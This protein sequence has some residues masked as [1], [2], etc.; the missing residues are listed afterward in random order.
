MVT[1]T[2]RAVSRVITGKGALSIEWV[3]LLL[4]AAL[5]I[6]LLFL[7]V[8]AHGQA[9]LGKN[10]NAVEYYKPPHDA[11]MK[12]LVQGASGER[13]PDGHSLL[14]NELKLQTFR[15]D[16]ERELL[17][18][19]PQCVYDEKEHFASSPG[20]LRAQSGKGELSIEGEGFLWQQTNSSLIISN[21]VHTVVRPDLLE[22][23]AAGERTNLPL[24]QLR[25]LEIYSDQFTYSAESGLGIYSGHVRVA[26]TNLSLVGGQLTIVV[27]IAERQLQSITAEHD[28]KVDYEGVSATGDRVRYEAAADQVQIIGQPE[29]QPSWRAGEREGRADDLLIDR[30]NK[31]F[32]AT[33]HAFLKMPAKGQ[34]GSGFL[35]GKRSPPETSPGKGEQT[36]EINCASYEIRTNYAV[37]H[38]AVQVTQHAGEA[39]QG[40]LTCDTLTASF[41]GTNELQNIIAENHVIL[42]RETSRFTADRA[43]FEGAEGLLNLTGKPAWRSGLR[44]G[45]GE[46]I[47]VNPE[48]EEMKVSG[49]AAMRLP[50]EQIASP[51]ALSFGKSAVTNAA[52]APQQFA[53]ITSHEYTLT[54]ET[55][56]FK[57]KVRAEHPQ[58]SW[59]CETITAQ[60]SSAARAG[61]VTAE[62][63]VV[64]D[65]SEEKV[66]GTS[67]KAVYTFGVTGNVT[68][69]FV[70]LT[71][72]PMLVTT[73]GVFQNSN[74]VII[75]DLAHKT[76]VAPGKF[77]IIGTNNASGTD[78]LQVPK[79]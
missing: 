61:R 49:D 36:V 69:D 6:T 47:R 9:V 56:L 64:F 32:R 59:Q 29:R 8:G 4:A 75:M 52:A 13:Q 57:G 15:E 53:Q 16:N 42:E 43:V 33:G 78:L 31:V 76:L 46:T 39:T 23:P 34:A 50:A 21:Q 58:M 41:S 40:T 62:Q 5:L 70:V 37:F 38:D 12:S 68:N 55:A 60:F 44:E 18:E 66:H 7:A 2:T 51:S 1:K 3:W 77:R 71:G 22:S 54:P 79:K 11:Q 19:A 63:D 65:L 67:D 17:V 73:N 25:N 10:F 45:S 20:R 30:T 28:V 27:P 24:N 26:G 35:P 48:K 14:V 74:N 72:N